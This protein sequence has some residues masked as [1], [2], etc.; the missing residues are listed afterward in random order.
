[1]AAVFAS[2]S[3]GIAVSFELPSSLC[4]IDSEAAFKK[5]LK[6]SYLNSH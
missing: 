1:M 2:A 3:A 5:Q 4:F 6:T